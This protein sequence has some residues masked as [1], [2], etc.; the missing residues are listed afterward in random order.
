[1]PYF[2][3]NKHQFNLEPQIGDGLRECQL[4]A[5][6]ALKSYKTNGNNE[7][8]SLVSMPTGS[9]KTAI[10][11]AACFEL[12]LRKILIVV[13]SKIL[14]RQISNQFRDLQ[15][16]KNQ[17][18]LRND[19]EAVSVY[20]VTNRKKTR[21]EWEEIIETHDV[22]VAHPNS[23]SPYYKGLAPIPED[24]ID[25][26]FMDEAHHEPAPTWQS[27][28]SFYKTQLKVFFTATPFRRDR[29]RMRAK[30]IYHYSLEQALVKNILRPIEFRGESLGNHPADSNEALLETAINVF[31]EERLVNPNSS[32]LIRTDRIEE[33][34]NLVTLYNDNGFNVDV[35]HSK[36]TASINENLIER[37]KSGD[38]DGLVC[39]GI[40]S[41]GLDIP[42]LKVAVLHA[43]PRSIPYTIQFL[44]RIS[45]TPINQEGP[46]KL[47]A[48]TDSVRGEVRRLYKSDSSWRVLIPQ[49]VDEQMQLAR[50]YRSSQAKEED[51]Q[52]PELNVYFSA[53]VYSTPDQF[54]FQ[55]QILSKSNSF[56][57][58]HYEQE[59][60]EAPLI[61]VT[62][63]NKPIDWASREI[64]IEDLLDVHIL[65]HASDHNLLFE[66]TTS[67]IALASFKQSILNV[68]LPTITH[69][70]LFKTLSQFSQ[71]DYLMVGMKNSASAGSSHPSYKTFVGSSVQA[72][73]RASEGRVFGTGHAVLRL[74]EENTWGVA[75][76]KGRVW[77]M[78]RGTAEEFKDWCDQLCTLISDG[79]IIT[80]LPGLSFLATTE[81]ATSID[82]IPIAIIPD[83][84][85]FKAYNITI[86]IA[87]NEPV[88]NFTPIIKGEALQD[89][90]TKLI[91]S[92]RILDSN[93]EFIFDLDGE[94]LW[95]VKNAQDVSVFAERRDKT[96]IDKNIEDVLN[97]YPPSLALPNGSIIV[98]R[99]KVIPNTS[100]EDLPDEIW[101]VKGWGGCNIRSEAYNENAIGNV[102]VINHTIELLRPSLVE[103]DIIFL[104]DGAHE[105]AD[106]IY[107]DTSNSTI[108]FI[109][110][111]YSGKDNPGCRKSDCDELFAQ[112]M[113][114][115]HW[116]S[117][118]ILLDRLNSRLAN[119]K[120]SQIVFGTEEIFDTLS[121]NYRVNNWKFNIILVQPGFRLSKA[122][123]KNRANNN[124]YEFAIPLYERIIGSNGTLEIWGN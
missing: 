85:F 37:V 95:S 110:C 87:N 64:Y 113:R 56:E 121:Q 61:V 15:I 50:H 57:I 34:N 52:M 75:T 14:R 21:Q 47:I 9:G 28:N 39:V 58:I 114:S 80:N 112:A 18:C 17:S 104:D 119:A 19:S 103:E 79:P 13:P 27:L 111:K 46:A 22:L 40:A 8:A 10:M 54:T 109:H 45:R 124:I 25:A 73:I 94:K 2:I 77:A 49:I 42:N 105:I 29:K 66:L 108:H 123:D 44:G 120:N 90:N 101:K 68:E 20:E 33:A 41:E 78:K 48:N 72:A 38:L 32:I 76:R 71:S 92:I 12:D 100:I 115:I 55:N 31:Q 97:E 60:N 53:L 89:N 81:P 84:L 83:D 86:S 16:L 98:G 74:D 35:I 93:F 107:F 88:R 65:Y 96:I 26:I 99:N 102:P 70:R 24:L 63:Y 30:L 43:T 59:N 122:S 69:G 91:G 7:V 5:I 4:G 6:W 62:A 82:E 117:S 116:I 1:M 51:F 23:I 106:L 118:P 67:E 11:M 3:D 36:R